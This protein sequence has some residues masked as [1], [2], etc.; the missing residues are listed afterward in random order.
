[1]KNAYWILFLALFFTSCDKA[2]S[3]APE[4]DLSTQLDL[5]ITKLNSADTK[6]Y[7]V[8]LQDYKLKTSHWSDSYKDG[9]LSI[10]KGIVFDTQLPT[11]ENLEIAIWLLHSESPQLLK[12]DETI[13]QIDFWEWYK[14]WDYLSYNDKVNN[15]YKNSTLE[16]RI[17]INGSNVMFGQGTTFDIVKATE[18]LVNGESKARVT[19]KLKGDLY[20]FYSDWNSPDAATYRVEGEFRGIIE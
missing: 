12:L 1:M 20:P 14:G 18:V 19:I 9:S 5:K 6:T 11:E 3:V 2:D 17:T 4:Q 8:S 15:F 10:S 13:T 7:T 16:R